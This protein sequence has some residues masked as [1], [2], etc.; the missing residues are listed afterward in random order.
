MLSPP[1]TDLTCANVSDRLLVGC[2][3]RTGKQ[4]GK[5]QVR[6]MVRIQLQIED[7][8]LS[9]V[10]DDW[11]DA[12]FDRYDADK[13]GMMDD[14]EWDSLSEILKTEAGKIGTPEAADYQARQAALEARAAELEKELLLPDVST[15]HNPYHNLVA[16]TPLRDCLWFSRAVVQ[17]AGCR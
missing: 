5:S 1:P 7:V 6:L 2:S 16:G 14:T 3:A 13:S 8:D 4:L 11:I 12:L 9:T 15:R 17:R 10:M